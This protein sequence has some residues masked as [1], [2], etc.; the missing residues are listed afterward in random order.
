VGAK[1]HFGAKFS[2]LGDFFREKLLGKICFCSAK[3]KKREKKKTPG[4]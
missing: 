3:T 4:K 1:Q 2:H